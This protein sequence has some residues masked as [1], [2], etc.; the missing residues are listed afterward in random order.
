MKTIQ[1]NAT[2]P[3]S[4]A[5]KQYCA[6]TQ[7]IL[8]GTPPPAPPAVDEGTK[9]QA[10]MI[11]NNMLVMGAIGDPTYSSMVDMLMQD[12]TSLNVA[13]LVP[14]EIV[15]WNAAGVAA[16]SGDPSRMLADATSYIAQMNNAIQAAGGLPDRAALQVAT[17]AFDTNGNI[18]IPGPTT[19]SSV[20]LTS[21]GSSQDPVIGWLYRVQANNQLVGGPIVNIDYSS[22]VV[23]GPAFQF[24]LS[25]NIKVGTI[26]VPYAAVRNQNNTTQALI[27][28][29]G[30]ITLQTLSS[31]SQVATDKVLG[32]T[33][34]SDPSFYNQIVSGNNVIV[35][36]YP[37]VLD[38]DRWMAVMR[39]ILHNQIGLL[40]QTIVANAQAYL[41]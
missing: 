6:L 14:R 30:G 1:I 36:A 10:Q 19:A 12:L 28:S 32:V 21:L 13:S 31:D 15:P 34:L 25:S 35:E 17:M 41:A 26:F 7:S 18:T 20:T 29:A 5:M 38:A 4:E 24:Q 40:G 9:R 3:A 27:P 8:T 39:L 22:A 2:I 16:L 23:G 37:V 33:G 11:L